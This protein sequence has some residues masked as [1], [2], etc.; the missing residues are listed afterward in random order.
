MLDNE[1][2]GVS[3]DFL[4][5]VCEALLSQ[6]SLDEPSSRQVRMG[7]VTLKLFVDNHWSGFER[8][9]LVGQDWTV[10]FNL[11]EPTDDAAH[12]VSIFKSDFEISIPHLT[13]ND[14]FLRDMTI[15][16]LTADGGGWTEQIS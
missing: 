5:K 4:A 6:T 10:G 16:K 9:M 8:Y 11:N 15:L 14:A 1:F 7:G 3:A 13:G 2:A 12:T